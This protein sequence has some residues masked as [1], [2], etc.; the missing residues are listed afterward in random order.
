MQEIYLDNSATTRVCEAAVDAVT[1]AMREDY[2][3]A[4]SLH[5]KGFEAQ[6]LLTEAK[7]TFASA[8][9]CAEGEV[10]FTSGA[11]ESNNMALIGGALARKRRGNKIIMTAIEHASVLECGKYLESQGFEVV[12]LP[13]DQNG[14]YRPMDFD[15]AVD[16]KTILVSAMLVNNEIGMVL[17]VEEIAKAVK[18]KN[19]E[20]LMHVDGV[21]GFLRY[22]MKLKNSKIDLFTASGHKVY[23]PKGIGLLYIRKGVRLVPLF[24]GGGQQNGVRVGTDNVPLVSGFAAAVKEQMGDIPERMAHFKELK[25][26]LL[27]LLGTIEGIAVNSRE[28][29]APYIVNISVEKIRSEVMLHYLEQYGIYVSSGSACSKGAKSHV[30]AALGLRPERIDTA[31]RISFSKDTT[32]EEL[33]VF[34]EKLK[35]GME[36]LAK[37]R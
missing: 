14:C 17:P 8:L 31:L 25:A 7:K 20:V 12:Y 28:G 15:Q 16:D 18:R 35:Q 24:Y 36:S 5:R 10:Y 23:G 11:T 22:P 1:S 9:N 6:K 37:I 26:Y 4:A 29:D 30:L 3:N 2:G 33:S 32:K 34:A 27:S 19:P 21:Q 13:P